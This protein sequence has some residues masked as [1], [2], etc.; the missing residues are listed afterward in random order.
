MAATV[1]VILNGNRD[2]AHRE[3]SADVHQERDWHSRLDEQCRDRDVHRLRFRDAPPA[4]G[5][6]GLLAICED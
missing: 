2:R 1:A 3:G 5:T 4:L 6:S